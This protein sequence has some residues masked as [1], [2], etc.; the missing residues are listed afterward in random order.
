[1]NLAV[2]IITLQGFKKMSSGPRPA[3]KTIILQIERALDFKLHKRLC[4]LFTRASQDFS[5]Q[6]RDLCG[7]RRMLFADVVSPLSGKE[8]S[9]RKLAII[10]G[11]CL[12]SDQCLNFIRMVRQSTPLPD[13][14]FSMISPLEEHRVQTLHWLDTIQTFKQ[15]GYKVQLD[16]I[17]PD[18]EYIQYIKRDF[19]D[20][21]EEKVSDSIAA[22]TSR[23]VRMNQ[24][25]L[26]QCLTDV[27]IHVT[28]SQ[29]MKERV[30]RLAKDIF[31]QCR[32]ESA[33]DFLYSRGITEA[34][35]TDITENSYAQIIF[36][37]MLIYITLLLHRY[38]KG[39]HILLMGDVDQMETLC[40]I[41]DLL[42][43]IVPEMS[44]GDDYS[45]LIY[46]SLPGFDSSGSGRYRMYN[47]HYFKSQLELNPHTLNSDIHRIIYYT[48]KGIRRTA[49]TNWHIIRRRWDMCPVFRFAYHHPDTSD[50]LLGDVAERCETKERIKKSQKTKHEMALSKM[51]EFC[52]R[53]SQRLIDP[54]AIKMSEISRDIHGMTENEKTFE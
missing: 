26:S 20:L 38:E 32:S 10:D 41:V 34:H 23:F 49:S 12:I 35:K 43:D 11:H 16:I 7:V 44:L 52:C 3:L 1:M 21:P 14:L 36:N 2:V 9:Q 46:R 22:V 50:I 28:N 24:F 37:F 25:V 5:Q 4:K 18:F 47:A 19:P 15:M 54:L 45:L 42:A 17:E 30:T 48:D 53:C 33:I 13:D 40:R 39:Y 29:D 8:L 27:E 6:Y 31:K 51:E